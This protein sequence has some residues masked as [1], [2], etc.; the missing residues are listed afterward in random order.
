MGKHPDFKHPSGA[1]E[2]LQT[3]DHHLAG[4]P[5]GPHRALEGGRQRGWAGSILGTPWGL[6]RTS[7]PGTSSNLVH[8]TQELCQVPQEG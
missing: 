1:Q 4:I 8:A 7:S 2:A 6:H 3:Q 5:L